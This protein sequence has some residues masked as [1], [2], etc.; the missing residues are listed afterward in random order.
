[1]LY[2]LKYLF[3]GC[4]K[5]SAELVDGSLLSI[6]GVV[7]A[8]VISTMTASGEWN[9]LSSCLGIILLIILLLFNK[10]DKI[11]YLRNLTLSM[12]ASL[13]LLII[14]ALPIQYFV[15]ADFNLFR[16]NMKYEYILR[17]QLETNIK[18]QINNPPTQEDI[19]NKITVGLADNFYLYDQV[20]KRIKDYEQKILDITLFCIW[21]LLTVIFYKFKLLQYLKD[22]LTNKVLKRQ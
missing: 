2:N 6:L 8:G 10:F 15:Q 20:D 12:S 11:S 17:Q 5:M 21:V 18:T 19:N 9:F 3:K 22:K 16:A 4:G 7:I 1:M 13:C 14:L